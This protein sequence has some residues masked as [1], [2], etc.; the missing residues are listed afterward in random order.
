MRF[1][2]PKTDYVF[3]KVFGSE[4]SHDILI[5]FLNAILYNSKTAIRKLEILNPYLAQRIRGVKA[6]YLNV[7]ATLDN[8]TTVIIE[9]QVLNIERFEKRILYNAAKAYST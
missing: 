6:T 7:K 9:M 1:I 4:Q 3:K 2:N 8:N 5:G